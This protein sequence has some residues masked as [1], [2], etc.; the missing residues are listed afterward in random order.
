MPGWLAPRL[1][2]S[3]LTLDKDTVLLNG[4]FDVDGRLNPGVW[5][6]GT[7]GQV[8][9]KGVHAEVATDVLSVARDSRGGTVLGGYF[10]N[11]NG[12]S[13]TDVARLN[14]DGSLDENWHPV[15]DGVVTAMATGPSGSVFILGNFNNVDGVRRAGLAKLLADGSL[16]R[17]WSPALGF[18]PVTMTLDANGDLYVGGNARSA[19]PDQPVHA[20]RHVSSATGAI[21]TQW[22]PTFVETADRPGV[23][24]RRIA[25]QQDY[26]FV[27]GDFSRVNAT[28]RNGLVKIS[29]AGTGDVD[30]HWNPPVDG[31]IRD[32]DVD[33]VDGIYIGGVQY[34]DDE[35]YPFL[36]RFSTQGAGLPDM[37][38]GVKLDPGG[39]VADVVVGADGSVYFN[40]S[41]GKAWSI[42]FAAGLAKFD[43]QGNL[44]TQWNPALVDARI[45]GTDSDGIYVG[46][47]LMKFG[48]T[49]R[50]S[51]AKLPY[52]TDAI[53]RDGFQ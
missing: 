52:N 19:Q 6:L 47:A 37:R 48:D 22:A 44:D 32:M 3:T 39:E 26:L 40:G 50:N 21:N 17:S 2:A 33:G 29:T 34:V 28:D 36:G 53:F 31:Y 18:I 1:Y 5:R 4:G 38:W 35:A 20:V 16:D 10:R 15:L 9:G 46:A 14:A 51:V 45:V 49:A 30:S 43:R 42:P 27:E 13:R 7:N 8:I 41:S 11:A 24:V 25:L 23:R 12:E